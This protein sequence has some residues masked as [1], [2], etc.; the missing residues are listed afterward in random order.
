[1]NKKTIMLSKE[2]ETKNTIRY[3]EET[4]GQPPVVQTIYIQKWFTGSPAPEKIRVTIEPV[5]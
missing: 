2:K 5:S 4:E 1:M 3:K